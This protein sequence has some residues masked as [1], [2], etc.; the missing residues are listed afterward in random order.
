[1]KTS[2]ERL[3]WALT[4]CRNIRVRMTPSRS[5]V[6]GYLSEQ[7]IPVD[8]ANIC[9]AHGVKHHCDETTVYRALML[10]KDAG[11]VRMVGTVGKTTQYVLNV[12]EDSSHFILCDRCGAVVELEVPANTR[13]AIRKLAI[14]HGFSGENEH[15]EVQGLCRRCASAGTVPPTTSKWVPRRHPARSQNHSKN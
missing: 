7:R 3:A 13:E 9:Q 14:K 1:M 2:V 6:L 11:L 10:F 4:T 12:P 5:S 15:L 8:L